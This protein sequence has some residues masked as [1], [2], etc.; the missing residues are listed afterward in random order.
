VAVMVRL[1]IDEILLTMYDQ[2][3]R[4]I[5]VLE[6]TLP[7]QVLEITIIIQAVSEM[8]CQETILQE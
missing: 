4:K 1:T 8:M 5:Q 2:T 7:I 3:I 6:I